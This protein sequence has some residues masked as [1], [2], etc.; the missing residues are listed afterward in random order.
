VHRSLASWSPASRG[1]SS[2]VN[3]RGGSQCHREDARARRLRRGRQRGGQGW[4]G[5]RVI[6]LGNEE[7]A[8][9]FNRGHARV[10][11]VQR[12]KLLV[13]DGFLEGADSLAIW[14]FDCE[15]VTK[16]VAKNQTIELECAGHES[17]W[18]DALSRTSGGSSVLRSPR[19]RVCTSPPSVR[20]FYC[21][22]VLSFPC[23]S[24][25][26]TFGSLVCLFCCISL[27]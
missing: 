13:L 24:Q 4:H 16:I 20:L 12:R 25:T 23:R 5:L 26:N 14:N 6:K 7:R 22:F 9:R 15:D 10:G 18:L 2:T 19:R 8:W 21:C 3:G 27:Y 11:G 17:Y 1:C